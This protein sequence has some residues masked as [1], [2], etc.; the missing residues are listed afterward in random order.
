MAYQNNKPLLHRKEFQ[1]M[2]PCPV[3]TGAGVFITKDPVGSRRT[4]LLVASNTVQYIYD[5]NEDAWQ[6]IPSLALAGTFAAG[7]CGGWGL[8]SNTLT[9]TGGTTTTITLTTA[10]TG[11]LEGRTVWFQTGASVVNLR[12]TITRVDIVPGGTNVITLDSAL[13]VA[14]PVSSTFKIDSGVYY[15]LNAYTAVAAGVFKSYD[16]A[17]GVATNLTTTN[18]PATWGVD[19][20]IVG[21]PS[22]VNTFASGTATAGG[23]TTLTNGAKTWTTNQW[24]NYQVRI[25]VGTGIGQVRTI[26]SN[27]GTVLTV[28]A[29]WTTNPDATSQY[30]IEGND[31]NL[32]ILGNGA[33]AMYRYSISANTITV[34]APGVAR[35]ASPGAGMGAGWIAK[36]DDIFW[37]N[38]SSII[39]GRYIYSFR[40]GSSNGLDRYDIALNT[41]SPISYIRQNEVFTTGSSWDVDGRRIYGMKE[42]SGRFFYYDVVDNEIIGFTTDFY[43]QSTAVVGDKMFTVSYDDGAGGDVIDWVYYLGNTATALRRIMIY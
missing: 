43:P 23:A 9:A 32:Y 21:T 41:W 7:A 28:S 30:V 11:K 15:V 12:R 5:V 16:V 17:T 33:V 3:T 31:D 42:G 27:T 13:P 39:N 38:E 2:S 19:G 1:M 36:T 14:T 29:A 26:S 4:A 25:T 34:L 18:L 6:N 10:I 35:A 37:E 8:W 24:S 22:Y 40:G 20:R